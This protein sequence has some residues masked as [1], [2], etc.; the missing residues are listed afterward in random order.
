M[1]YQNDDLRK[2]NFPTF[3]N[4]DVGLYVYESWESVPFQLHRVFVIKAGVS[5]D[6]GAHAH[7]KCFQLLVALSGE[8]KVTCDDSFKKVEIILNN[9]SEGLLIPPTIWAEQSY[10]PGTSLMVL[11]D[12]LYEESDYLR[13]YKEFVMFRRRK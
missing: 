4:N 11:T 10:Q 12:M 13:D 7:K 6:R 9:T 1:L 5:C 2:I 8:C 3:G